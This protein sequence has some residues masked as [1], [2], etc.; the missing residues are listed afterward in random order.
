[1]KAYGGRDLR[2]TVLSL[3]IP[4]DFEPQIHSHH[5]GVTK[6]KMNALAYDLALSTMGVA[7]NEPMH[8]QPDLAEWPE[9]RYSPH[10][11]TR[12][13]QGV[14]W[15]SVHAGVKS[16]LIFGFAGD[17][18]VTLPPLGQCLVLGDAVKLRSWHHFRQLFS[19]NYSSSAV[20]PRPMIA[21]TQAP[22]HRDV[23]LAF[24]ITGQSQASRL[25]RH[26]AA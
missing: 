13:R 17:L 18:V 4:P 10:G 14:W 21:S 1:M 9:S 25:A 20:S 23:V 8:A 11:D 15:R 2:G 19:T 26:V 16:D 6:A 22:P 12:Q 7:N 3:F 5:S 24:T